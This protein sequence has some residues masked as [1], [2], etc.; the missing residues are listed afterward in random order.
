LGLV[1]LGKWLNQRGVW[2]GQNDSKVPL[3]MFDDSQ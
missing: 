3:T 2:R 1:Y